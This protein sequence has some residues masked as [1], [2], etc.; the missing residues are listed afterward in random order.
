MNL[1]THEKLLV[2]QTF[3]QIMSISD[4]AA[5][6]FY[7]R[8]FEI[9][10]ESKP[11]FDDTN[12]IEMRKKFID[13]I[14]TV[15]YSLDSIEQVKQAIRQLGE[16]HKEYGVDKPDYD[17]V[18]EAFLWM[19]KNELS[20]EYTSEVQQAWETVYDWIFITATDGLYD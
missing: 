19:L 15:V 13:M 18:R 12:M 6:K 9:A 16:R 4:R 2:T 5:T 8:L 1:S 7:N 14:A 11:M 10:P 20:T 3:Y 17:K